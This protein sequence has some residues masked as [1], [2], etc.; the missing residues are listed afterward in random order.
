M[1]EAR[2]VHFKFSHAQDPVLQSHVTLPRPHRWC[3]DSPTRLQVSSGSL[4]SA[5]SLVFVV[6]H[7]IRIIPVYIQRVLAFQL[8]ARTLSC[9]RDSGIPS[10]GFTLGREIPRREG[11]FV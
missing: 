5:D 4:D 10:T 1:K 6:G 7:N 3:N 2:R 11:G 9:D 8:S